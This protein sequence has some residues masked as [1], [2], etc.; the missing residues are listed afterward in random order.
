MFGLSGVLKAADPVG[1]RVAVQ[2]YSLMPDSWVSPV[3]LVLPYFELALAL[4]LLVG[5]ATRLTAVLS[6]LLLL[7][8]IAGVLSAA[9]RGLSIDCGCFG[10][11]GTVAPG[12]TSYT[13]EVLR[14]VGF[15]A[16]AAWLIWRPVSPL[17]LD[18][19]ATRAR[20]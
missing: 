18:R 3:A 10:G 5:L 12:E 2:A 19:W 15:L 1:T 17:S 13:A 8:F 11:G 7:V 14:D 16:L 9:A 6:A 4:L 20:A